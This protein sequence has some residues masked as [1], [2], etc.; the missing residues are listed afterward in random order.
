MFLSFLCVMTETYRH[1]PAYFDT[2]DVQ[3]LKE[4]TVPAFLDHL[5]L[6]IDEHIAK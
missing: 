4:K 5:F 3:A 2:S 6:K 1:L